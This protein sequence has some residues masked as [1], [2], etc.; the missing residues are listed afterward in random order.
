MGQP[1]PP[2]NGVEGAN[3]GQQPEGGAMDSCS[4]SS[5][6]DWSRGPIGG[7]ANWRVGPWANWGGARQ[8][9]GLQ[10]FDQP[11]PLLIGWWDDQ[12]QDSQGEGLQADGG[13]GCPLEVGPAKREAVGDWLTGPIPRSGQF[14][15]TL[16]VIVTGC[17]GRCG[18]PVT[19]F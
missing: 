17:L 19:G 11:S 2:S 4:A 6:P 15:G 14:A 3:W 16:G 9:E 5:D 10:E 7:G 8:G 1:A 13:S 18:I 12:S